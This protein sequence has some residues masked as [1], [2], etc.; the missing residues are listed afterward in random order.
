MDNELTA[1][2]FIQLILII[3]T[4]TTSMELSHVDYDYQQHQLIHQT[5]SLLLRVP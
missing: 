5:V 2:I 4:P 1:E 3:H